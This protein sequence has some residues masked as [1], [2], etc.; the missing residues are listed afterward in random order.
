MD[1]AETSGWQAALP[2]DNGCVAPLQG[3]AERRVPPERA[4]LPPASVGASPNS[5]QNEIDY[6]FTEQAVRPGL[7][8]VGTPLGNPA[9]WS[10]RAQAVLQAVDLVACEDTRRSGLL[11][12][13]FGI[14]QHLISYHEHNKAMRTPGLLRF[15][16]QGHS[17][18][19]VTDAGMPAI[20]DP[21]SDLAAAAAE[22]GFPITVI[23]GPTAA[24]TA[25]AASGLDSRRFTFEGFLPVKGKDRSLRLKQLA[26]EERTQILYEAPH[27]LQKTLEELLLE[28]LGQRRLVLGREL[29][30]RYEEYLRLTVAQARA[31]YQT[32][33]PLG[34]FTLILEGRE[35]FDARQPEPEPAVAQAGLEAELEPRLRDLLQA[36]LSVKACAAR[37]S[38]ETGRPRNEL[39][40]LCLKLKDKFTDL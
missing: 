33:R 18:A 7:Y 12:A 17:L 21:G 5:A 34:E 11:L 26:Q 9:D 2:R 20:S 38:E 36:G 13:H 14:K 39:Y 6:E 24:M 4:A 27:R 25:L 3:T 29:T 15:L 32:V 23:P 19:L 8:L 35:A 37:L 1:R 10:A 16:S 28:G 22:A 40:R 31:Y 30:K